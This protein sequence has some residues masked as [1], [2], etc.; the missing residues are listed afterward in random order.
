MYRSSILLKHFPETST[1]STNTSAISPNVCAPTGFPIA[2]NTAW[3]S[4]IR[5]EF[6]WSTLTS[7]GQTTSL[8]ITSASIA[9]EPVHRL[10]SQF[11]MLIG[12]FISSCC[13]T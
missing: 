5:Q 3:P 8:V 2:T 6:N 11:A 7:A 10:P 13:S 9:F 4:M 12:M 1:C